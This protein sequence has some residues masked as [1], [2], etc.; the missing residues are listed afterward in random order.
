MFLRITTHSFLTNGIKLY[1]ASAFHL[2]LTFLHLSRI[3]VAV[4]PTKTMPGKFG[5]FQE[6][7]ESR[8]GGS[9]K[10]CYLLKI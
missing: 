4:S 5:K 7:G 8:L 2:C 10:D 3:P 1:L 6:S 9:E